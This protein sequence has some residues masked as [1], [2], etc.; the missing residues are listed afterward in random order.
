MDSPPV[1][2]LLVANDADDYV[3][4]R[5]LLE[6]ER[7]SFTFDWVVTYAAALETIG[8]H[9]HDVYLL[10]SRLGERNGLELLRDSLRH[11]CKA[12]MILLTGRGDSEVDIEAM[13]AGAADYLVKGQIDATLLARSLRYSVER[14]RMLESLQESEERYRMAEGALSLRDRAL[15]AITEG[16][17]ITDPHQPDN[18]IVYVNS[19]FERLTGYSAVEVLGRNC[20]FLQ[21]PESDPA[22]LDAVRTAICEE[23]ECIVEL[24]NY[25]KDGMPFWNRLSLAPVRNAAG[26]VVN[27]IGVQSDVT[28]RKQMEALKSE[29]LSI[30]G[31]Q[32]RT[33][34]TSLRGFVELM[35]RRDYTPQERREFLTIIHNETKSLTDLITDFLDIQRTEADR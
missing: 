34:L 31:H 5:D 13:Q 25:R 29:L 19:G 22:V 1:R 12:P 27:F 7:G 28:K 6:I 18:P 11:G 26:A 30:L 32:L 23:R 15:A 33:P 21:G 20:R 35:L 24:R 9:E 8:R 17:C 4:L 3:I 14:A 2:V 16:I 10:D